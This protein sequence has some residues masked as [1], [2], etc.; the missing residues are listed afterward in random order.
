MGSGR[1]LEDKGEEEEETV[2]DDDKTSIESIN[3]AMDDDFVDKSQNSKA[4]CF[5]PKPNPYRSSFFFHVENNASV[6]CISSTE[7]NSSRLN[8]KCCNAFVVANACINLPPRTCGSSSF[9][10]LLFLIAPPRR[11]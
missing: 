3:L 10:M 7:E 5:N 4:R 8:T 6:N 9:S 1:P 2:G 11:R